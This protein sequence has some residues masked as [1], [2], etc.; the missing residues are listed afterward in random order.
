[1]TN[2]E[3]SKD[4]APLPLSKSVPQRYQYT[5]HVSS[6]LYS[7]A[8]LTVD[9][10]VDFVGVLAVLLEF[11]SPPSSEQ[12]L[13]SKS[14]TNIATVKPIRPKYFNIVVTSFR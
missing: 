12:A 8:K 13:E 9:L 10:V 14:V 6:F 7:S 3:R 1:M 2:S 4:A 5:I 11:C